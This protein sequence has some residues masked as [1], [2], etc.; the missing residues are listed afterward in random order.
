MGSGLG[1]ACPI[2][3]IVTFMT[4][5]QVIGFLPHISSEDCEA[6]F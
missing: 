6:L 4:R 1:K 5:R 2:E 3:K